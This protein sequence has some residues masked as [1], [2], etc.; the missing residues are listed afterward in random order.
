MRANA[1]TDVE[2]YPTKGKKKKRQRFDLSP[3]PKW[4]ASVH[5]TRWVVS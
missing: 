3:K 1:I 2:R 4:N 5:N